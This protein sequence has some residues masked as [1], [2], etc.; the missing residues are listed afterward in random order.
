[1]QVNSVIA[2]LSSQTFTVEPINYL[3]LHFDTMYHFNMTANIESTEF[4]DLEQRLEK[5][6]LQHQLDI[7]A[8]DLIS[9]LA[10]V[11][12]A[13][14]PTTTSDRE[15]LTQHAGL[16]DADLSD[17]N[18]GKV[19]MVINAN[20]SQ[21]AVEV[22]RHTLTTQE[23]AHKI[24]MAPANVRR[25]VM[26]GTLYSVKSSPGAHHRFPDWQFVDDRPLP[27]LREVI[28]ALPNDYHP[29]EIADFMTEPAETLKN[30]SPVRWL[31]AGGDIDNVVALADER[32]WE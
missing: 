23:V 29:L 14:T 17:E 22:Q 7:K 12:D 21:A 25:S 27:G 16:T 30:M 1:M 26:V 15:F 28:S 5:A 9:L 3:A 31:S 4:Q 20:R 19:D 2:I 32:S 8:H 13:S 18:V 24:G 10:D 6:I 11:G